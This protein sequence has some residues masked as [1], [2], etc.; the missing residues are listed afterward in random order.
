MNFK[1]DDSTRLNFNNML[2]ESG[3]E[4]NTSKIRKLKHSNKIREQVAIM[5]DIRKKYARLGKRG[6]NAMIDSKCTWLFTH[7]TNKLV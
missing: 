6:I 1:I 7:Y 2:K 3:A 5:M 4:D